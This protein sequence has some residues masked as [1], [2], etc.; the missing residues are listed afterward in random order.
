MTIAVR[1]AW[2]QKHPSPSAQSGEFH[3]H[4]A[5][6]DR[7]L[8]TSCVERLRGIEPPAV[9]WQLAPGHVAWAQL[10]AATTTLDRR[11]YVGVVLTIAEGAGASTVELLE[12]LVLPPAAP[13]C[14]DGAPAEL[15]LGGRWIAVGAA[16]ELAIGTSWRKAD[17]ASGEAG[18]RAEDVAG[19]ARALLA[20][21]SAVVADPE[22][23]QLPRA[24]AEVERW[25]PA[26][27][28]STAR[29]GV[30]RGGTARPAV[31]PVADLI[32]AAWRAPEGRAA[33]AW[34]LLVELAAARGQGVDAVAGELARPDEAL[35]AALTEAERGSLG[36]TRG[37]VEV[38]HAW[39]RGR[40]DGCASAA[41]LPARLADHAAL[42]ALARLVEGRDAAQAI[43]EVRWRALRPSA[44]RAQLLDAIAGRTAALRALVE[45]HHA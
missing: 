5:D 13:W 41:S 24:I 26:P 8:R 35:R 21:G 38:V 6:V 11:R 40:L 43:A 15:E 31:D 19:V 33:Q 28:R 16:T 10:F 7:E 14:S 23:E 32:A 1:H 25:L 37:F 39:G 27:V 17:G 44:R 2:L 45:G 3:W 20:G 42:R 12:A 4:P 36:D 18:M 34:A 29:R 22:H 30:W 9:L